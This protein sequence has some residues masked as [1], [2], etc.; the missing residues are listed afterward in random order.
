MEVGSAVMHVR[1]VVCDECNYRSHDPPPIT[2]KDSLLA[3]S[4]KL[5]SFISPS[6][7]SY[8]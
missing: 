8:C 7:G 6:S 3:F 1:A 5:K 4:S 2:G